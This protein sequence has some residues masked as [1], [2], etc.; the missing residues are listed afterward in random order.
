MNTFGNRFRVSIFGES[1]GP[2]IGVT[3]DGVLPGMPLGE[4]DFAEDLGRRKAGAL[5]TNAKR[6]PIGSICKSRI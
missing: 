6:T 1:H 5:G 2:R 4:E 3:V